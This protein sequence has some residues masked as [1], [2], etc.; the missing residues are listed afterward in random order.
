MRRSLD[1]TTIHGTDLITSRRY[2]LR[3][4]RAMNT[5]F[6]RGTRLRLVVLLIGSLVIAVAEAA[7]MVAVLPLMA[8]AAGDSPDSSSQL[9]WLSGLLGDPSEAQLAT[10]VAALVLAGFVIKGLGSLAFRWWSIGFILRQSIRTSTGLLNYYLKAPY[11]LH[12]QRGTPDLLRVL[13]EGAGAVYSAVVLGSVAAATELITLAAL[14]ITLLIVDPVSTVTVA[15]YFVVAA[16]AL[17][18]F[19][20]RR[21]HD[22][23][24]VLLEE[25]RIA[26][27]TTLQG[28][29]GIK[30]IQLRHEQDMLVSAYRASKQRS[31][32]AQR[33]NAFLTDLPKYVLEILFVAGVGLMTALAYAKADR[34]EALGTVALFGVAGFRILPSI[35]RCLASLTLVRAGI[36]ALDLVEPDLLHAD[37]DPPVD[38]SP[39]ERLPLTRELVLDALSFRYPGSVRDVL[40][41]VSLTIAAG[42]S[43]AFVGASGAGKTTLVDIILGFHEPTSGEVRADGTDVF[44]DLPRWRAGLAM[45]PQD[46]YLLDE[47]LRDNIR[48]TAAPLRTLIPT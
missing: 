31:A 11:A 3:L 2:A 45:V 46:V 30:E 23:S 9:R 24:V 43:V 29:G 39:T 34:A 42:S 19:A 18:R 41:D 48:F 32:R 12:V 38:A 17:Q 21:V 33:T 22:A 13:N 20:K 16:W 36:P 27:K 4:L 35:V 6:D 14:S 47:S 8:L 15:V 5:L 26:N 37:E 40:T 25:A 7:A 1:S 10:Y 44:G 28:L